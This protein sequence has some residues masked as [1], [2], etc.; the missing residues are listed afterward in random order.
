LS[1]RLRACAYTAL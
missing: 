1:S